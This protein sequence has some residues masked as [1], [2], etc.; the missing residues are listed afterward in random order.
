MLDQANLTTVAAMLEPS[1][2]TEVWF[3]PNESCLDL[4][5]DGVE[6][7]FSGSALM[8]ACVCGHANITPAEYRAWG[9]TYYEPHTEQWFELAV[10]ISY[11]SI[12][13]L[14]V[15]GNSL[16]CYVVLACSRMRTVTNYLLANMAAGDLLMSILCVPFTFPSV[17]LLRHW[18]FG[19]AMCCLV[20]FTQAV[21]VFVSAFSLIAVSMDRYRA[22]VFPLRPRVTRPHARLMILLIWLLSL[23]ACVPIAVTSRT[24]TPSSPRYV[25]GDLRVCQEVWRS[26]GRQYYS[27]TVMTLQYFLPVLV[28]GY[29]YG[30]VAVEVWGRSSSSLFE[31]RDPREARLVRTRRKVG[32]GLHIRRKVGQGLCTR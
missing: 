25:L 10:W 18:P 30:R 28:L 1:N 8:Q 6:F 31:Q 19:S 29:T 20:S 14:S 9:C 12:M 32:Q 26:A 3:W 4:H 5:R 2:L 7:N 11:I 22:I 21:S 15:V 17:I 23:A 24:L 13:L 16:V 27:L